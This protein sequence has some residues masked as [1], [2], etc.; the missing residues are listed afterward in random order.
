MT[1]DISTG[2]PNQQEGDDANAAKAMS[3][4]RTP[5]YAAYNSERYHRQDLI[6]EIQ[7]ESEFRLISY[8]SSGARIVHDD[9]IYFGD[10]LH[11]ISDGENIELL[12]HTP[13][14]DIDAADKLIHMIREKVS[15]A[16]FRIIVPHRAKSAGTLMVLGADQVVMSDSSELGPIDPQVLIPNGD[17]TLNWVAAQHYL[18]A[19]KTHSEALRH[20]PGDLP[21]QMMFNK[22][23]PVVYEQ[24][25]R[26]KERSRRLAERLLKQYMFKEGGGNWTEI[27]DRLIDTEE[28]QTHSQGISLLD[29]MDIGLRV[30]RI[31]PQDGLWQ[32]YWRLYCLQRLAID[33][34]QKLFE[35][36]YVSL[37]PERR[38]A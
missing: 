33:D 2:E 20:D 24:C 15:H 23:D 36:D 27:A 16:E 32:K 31:K 28:W 21:S 3:P 8:V 12:L 17:G 38:V 35:S 29:A 5:L 7:R 4:A 14:G 37:L 26:A 19:Y 1:E 11:G 30:N 10:L 9:E 6:K 25:V 13:G 22:L 18:D 34:N